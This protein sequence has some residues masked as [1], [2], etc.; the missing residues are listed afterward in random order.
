MPKNTAKLPSSPSG[1]FLELNRC[2]M[3][4]FTPPAM[5]EPTP[6]PCPH[7]E[8]AI[9]LAVYATART[10]YFRCAR[11]HEVWTLIHDRDCA[12]QSAAAA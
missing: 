12:P 5:P 11:C 1:T 7:C 4:A 9:S 2:A 8:N 6:T 10:E 3:F